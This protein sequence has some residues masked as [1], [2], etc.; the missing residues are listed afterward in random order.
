VASLNPHGLDLLPVAV[1]INDRYKF[2]KYPKPEDLRL[3]SNPNSLQFSGGTFRTDPGE[4]III[5]LEIYNDGIVAETRSNTKY[6]DAFLNDLMVFLTK[7]FR[8]RFEGSMV[9]E[10]NYLSQVV[11]SSADF[12][13]LA[14]P[15]MD[16][17]AKYLTSKFRY[18]GTSTVTGMHFGP[19]PATTG[20]KSYG[21]RLE[22]KAATPFSENAYFSEAPLTTDTHIEALEKL[23]EILR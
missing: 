10:S 20:G 3:V 14:D 18:S 9:R 8:L 2:Q 7:S 16:S 19:D 13:K 4:W 15:K 6:T 1:A 22:R 23:E 11:V 12:V 17:Y 21:L 5:R